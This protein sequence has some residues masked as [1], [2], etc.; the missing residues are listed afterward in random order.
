MLLGEMSLTAEAI[1]VCEAGALRCIVSEDRKARA[2]LL[3]LKAVLE[4]NVD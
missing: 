2:E 4:E 1:A 3:S